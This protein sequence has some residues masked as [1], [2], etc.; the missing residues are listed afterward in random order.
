MTETEARYSQPK[1]ELCG[2]YKAIRKLRYHLIG[3]RFILEVDAMSL[4]QMINKPDVGNATMIRWIANLKEYDFTIRHIPGKHHVF[5]MASHEQTSTTQRKRKRGRRTDMCGQSNTPF[6]RNRSTRTM[7]SPI[8]SSRRTSTS[9]ASED[10][11]YGSPPE[12][13]IPTFPNCPDR[14]ERESAGSS[15]VS[16]WN[17]DDCIAGT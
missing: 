17:K 1:L 16:S 15:A 11:H 5:P 8:T 7:T 14:N 6:S 10:S 9:N 12:G 4:R 13:P 3:T 2:V